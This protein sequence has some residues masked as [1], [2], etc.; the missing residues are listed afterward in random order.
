MRP[1]HKQLQ[2]MQ[3]LPLLSN[4][5]SVHITGFATLQTSNYILD[6][7]KSLFKSL[8]SQITLIIRE[9]DGL[10]INK[11]YKADDIYLGTKIS[12][13]TIVFEVSMPEKETKMS[14]SM[15]KNQE[16]V[17]FFDGVKFKWKQKQITG[18]VELN[19]NQIFSFRTR[20]QSEL[21]SFEHTFDRKHKDKVLNSYFPSILCWGYP[22]LGGKRWW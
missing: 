9:F 16:I 22:T 21:N 20:I 1:L 8:S 4:S 7:T 5:N 12:P 2:P 17:D 14:I 6:R 15:T 11:I 13:S 19:S 10:A 3:V 18:Q